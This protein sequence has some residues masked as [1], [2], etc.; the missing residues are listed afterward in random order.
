M[1]AEFFDGEKL[2]GRS[3]LRAADPPMGVAAGSFEP[4]EAY[5]RDVHANI[6]EGDYV[7]D[8]GL[9]LRSRS[10]DRGDIEGSIVIE[11]YTDSLGERQVSV[12]AIPYPEYGEYFADDP[13]HRSY[14]GLDLS[15]EERRLRDEAI[16]ASLR[17]RNVRAWLWLG[18]ILLAF[19]LLALWIF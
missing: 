11:D 13:G 1:R 4:T 7:G 17:A 16:R 19:V 6:I 3:V 14:W 10:P 12:I 2:I 5:S 18:G 15:D 9:S 8:R